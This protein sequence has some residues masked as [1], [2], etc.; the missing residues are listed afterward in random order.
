L[1]G[2]SLQAAVRTLRFPA[3]FSAHRLLNMACL[4][5]ALYRGVEQE[6]S[7]NLSSPTPD[8]AVYVLQLV[9]WLA[10]V[11][12][13]DP[14]GAAQKEC[15]AQRRGL[16][17][18]VTLLCAVGATTKLS[19]AAFGAALTVL[20]WAVWLARAGGRPA[21]WRAVGWAALLALT[22][23]GGPWALRGVIASG[24]PAFPSSIGRL[25][26]DYTIPADVTREAEQWVYSFARSRGGEIESVLGSWDWL[27][28]WPRTLEHALNQFL[29]A[30]PMALAAAAVA[31]SIVVRA[32]AALLRRRVTDC[33]WPLL[34]A[35][36]AA[37][38]VVFWFLT[39]P[40]PRFG[41]AIFWVLALSASAAFWLTFL[42]GLPPFVWRAVALAFI[43]AAAAITLPQL[44][45][46]NPRG[47]FPTPPKAA[48][49]EFETSSG[50]RYYTV[51]DPAERLVWDSPLPTS[52]YRLANLELRGS[53]IRDGFRLRADQ[54]QP[55]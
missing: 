40:D 11:R 15:P 25:N 4:P 34:M 3:E 30:L 27:S 49:V 18:F 45:K 31:L 42:A 44:S 6:F 35:A 33:W 50:L 10:A 36:P 19:F 12:L 14:A 22:L 48:L 7:A 9:A 41:G 2:Q 5:L 32:V 52:P 21:A 1:V 24:Y 20:V 39:A 46:F 47:A 54:N 13:L 51:A 16:L 26:L 53:A 55:R 38:A 37:A 8:L 43:G 17:H 23:A 28:Y 29:F